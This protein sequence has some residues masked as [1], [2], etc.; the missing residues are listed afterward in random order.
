MFDKNRQRTLNTNTEKPR[1]VS[2]NRKA[3]D[4]LIERGRLR[5][6]KSESRLTKSAYRPSV[7]R[8]SLSTP[9]QEKTPEKAKVKTPLKKKNVSE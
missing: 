1:S 5:E 3:V 8:N 7:Q 4:N 2:A 9:P 6:D